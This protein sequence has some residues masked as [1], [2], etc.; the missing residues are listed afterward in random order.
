MI[1]V[2]VNVLLYSVR[3]GI[4]SLLKE[5]LFWILEVIFRKVLFVDD[6]R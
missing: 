2:V 6:L 4:V 3:P 5:R 1:G